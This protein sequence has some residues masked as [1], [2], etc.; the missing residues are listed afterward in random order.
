MEFITTQKGKPR[1]QLVNIDFPK[2]W[3]EF[4]ATLSGFNQIP[5]VHWFLAC[6]IG[7][8]GL[9]TSLDVCNGS[10]TVPQVNPST[11]RSILIPTGQY[12]DMHEQQLHNNF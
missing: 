1:M 10:A 3:S 7:T 8:E 5:A 12:P 4:F 2:A 9:D 6:V 11:Q